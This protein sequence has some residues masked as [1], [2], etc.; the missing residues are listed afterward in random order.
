M[1]SSHMLRYPACKHD[2]QH[3]ITECGPS[4]NVTYDAI[5]KVMDVR[6]Q[7]R[8]YVMELM[9][10]VAKDG[11][12]IN[13]PLSW[14]FP[15]DSSAW[16]IT[17]QFMFGHKY[18]VAPITDLGARE[19]SVYFPAGGSCTAWEAVDSVIKVRLVGPV[20]LVGP[21]RMVR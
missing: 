13:R 16:Y 10:T 9:K 17:D 12:P 6:Q 21:S 20:G 11:E 3:N 8:P 5:I 18:M 2:R 1:T 4:G 19:R 15:T 14:D 7:L